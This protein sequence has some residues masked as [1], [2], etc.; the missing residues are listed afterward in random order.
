ML[1][2]VGVINVRVLVDVV[3]PLGIERAGPA[4]DAVD[5]VA[6][7]KQKFGQVRAVLAGDAGDEGGFGLG[8]HIRIR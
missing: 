8:G 5:E 7:V 6:F 2:E 4:L 3:D 1:L